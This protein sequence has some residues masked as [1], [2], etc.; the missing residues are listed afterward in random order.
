M[1]S[2][3]AK[4][5]DEIPALTASMRAQAKLLKICLKRE[6]SSHGTGNNREDAAGVGEGRPERVG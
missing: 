5:R 1:D 4:R 3:R 6:C 2:D